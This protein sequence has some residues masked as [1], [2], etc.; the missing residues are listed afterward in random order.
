[1]NK[2][3][4]FKRLPPIQFGVSRVSHLLDQCIAVTIT[5]LHGII[6]KLLRSFSSI[7]A[8]NI[9]LL[10]NTFNESAENIFFSL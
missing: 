4:P 2:L 9:S 5:V 10:L 3:L 8:T 1:M 7:Y 6:K